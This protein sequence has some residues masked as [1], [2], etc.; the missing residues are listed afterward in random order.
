MV[1]PG[2]NFGPLCP[3]ALTGNNPGYCGSD[4]PTHDE[5]LAQAW[6]TDETLKMTLQYNNAALRTGLELYG[7]LLTSFL[8]YSLILTALISAIGNM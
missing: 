4:C 3:T 1:V 2:S 7:I 6:K 8:L 5:V